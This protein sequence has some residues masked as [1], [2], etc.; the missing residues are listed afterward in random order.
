MPVVLSELL[1]ALDAKQRVLRHRG[2]DGAHDAGCRGPRRGAGSRP[3]RGGRRARRAGR[4]RGP[5]D[6]RGRQPARPATG[7]PADLRAPAGRGGARGDGAERADPRAQRLRR[8]WTGVRADRQRR[9][10][11]R[12]GQHRPRRRVVA[13]RRPGGRR[14]LPA[15][16]DL[17]QKRRGWSSRSG[18][19]PTRSATRCCRSSTPTGSGR[20]GRP[21]SAGATTSTRAATPATRCCATSTTCTSPSRAASAALTRPGYPV[22][23]TSAAEPATLGRQ[24]AGASRVPGDGG[25][26]P[27]VGRGQR[28][29]HVAGAGRA[30]ERARRD[31]DAQAGQALD[32]RPAVLVAG[33]PE[34]EAGLRVVD[35]EAGPRSARPALL[36]PCGVAGSS[37]PRRARRRRARPPSRPGPA[38]APSSR[39]AC[40]PRAARRPAPG[41]RPRTPPGSRPG[42]TA[43]TASRPRAGPR[44]SPPHTSGC[45]SDTGGA[46]SPSR[47]RGSTRRRPRPRR[48]PGPSRRPCAGARRAA[49]G[50]SGWTAS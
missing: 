10:R 43:W 24:P 25:G 32:R 31:Q 12:R 26:D 4:D 22:S 17:E 47:A 38:P 28:D 19:S 40:A 8:A 34:V 33:G 2:G 41:R 39:R 42:S 16:G 49:P 9:L 23:V 45:S 50:R 20:R 15:L 13:L 14:V 48:A 7:Q 3:G 46:S 11:R 35:P 37:A 29:A 36:T 21:T 44:W 5:G 1:R 30:V 18:W 6:R 27:L